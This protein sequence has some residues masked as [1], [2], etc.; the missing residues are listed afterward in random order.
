MYVVIDQDAFDEVREA[1]RELYDGIHNHMYKA[2]M[3]LHVV[4]LNKMFRDLEWTFLEDDETE[5]EEPDGEFM[6]A[7]EMLKS[8]SLDLYK[9]YCS[10][11]AY[12]SCPE[13]DF[14]HELL[15]VAFAV[16][17]MLS[18]RVQDVIPNRIS[19]LE[20]VL[21]KMCITEDELL[22]AL[23]EDATRWTANDLE[24]LDE[25]DDPIKEED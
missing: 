6:T 11:A 9:H 17:G 18:V 3:K 7:E 8:F 23:K 13:D 21:D 16:A 15:Q 19:L 1:V 5:E 4:K 12:R 10:V 2:D 14:E 24:Q 25:D 22:V 20:R